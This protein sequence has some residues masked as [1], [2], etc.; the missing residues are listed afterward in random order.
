MMTVLLACGVA[1][2]IRAGDRALADGDL[3]AAESA[4]RRAVEGEPTNADALYGLGWT[5]HL[6]D[7]QDAA[8]EAFDLCV[9]AHPDA[10]S[11]WRGLGSVAMSAQN[12]SLARQRFEKALTVAP[13]DRRA[14]HSLALLDLV[15]GDAE[16][17]L[18]QLDGLV[19][20]APEQAE[21][22]QGRAE[23]LLRLHRDEEAL[24]AAR[25]A[26]GNAEGARLQAVTRLTLVRALLAAS[27]GR[28]DARDCAHTALPV[29]AW[30]DEADRLVGEV[31]TGG[32][33]VPELAAVR[34]AV[35]KRRGET[36]EAC[37]GVRTAG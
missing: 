25:Q 15:A 33:R 27:A 22:H 21:F 12:P 3:A 19:A 5:Y 1:A 9:A 2:D 18:K 24:A 32:V 11:C 6:A 26:V 29:H 13:D 28:V 17:A 34:R 20:E 30:I 4:Y 37:P 36:D 23:A 16:A 31:E 35:R 8:R 14:R 7:Q 10:A